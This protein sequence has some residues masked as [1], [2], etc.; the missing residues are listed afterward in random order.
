MALLWQLHPAGALLRDQ[1]PDRRTRAA[2]AGPRRRARARGDAREPRPGH[3]RVRSWPAAPGALPA[4]R[5]P[6]PP[7][8]LRLA[9]R[10][11]LPVRQVGDHARPA[12]AQRGGRGPLRGHPVRMPAP[13]RHQGCHGAR[14]GGRRAR[15]P[16]AHGGGGD[17]RAS[18]ARPA[19]DEARRAPRERRDRGRHAAAA[20]SRKSRR[21]SSRNGCRGEGDRVARRRGRPRRARGGR[22]AAGAARG[23][24]C[25]A[26]RLRRRR[27][28]PPRGR[29]WP[30]PGP[31]VAP[32]VRAGRPR[33]ASRRPRRRP[34]RA[35][36][37][38]CGRRHGA[39]HAPGRR[40]RA[41]AA[42]RGGR[43]GCQGR[44]RA[45]GNDARR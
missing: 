44:A 21:R 28:A 30:A 31:S 24:G 11:R 37:R 6:E 19:C 45:M 13:Y 3:G 12:H 10:P 9:A 25:A 20:Y 35:V 42:A 27:P 29:R 16:V 14:R 36:G 33:R 15:A 17:A 26:A 2:C 38:R 8:A 23:A 4:A 32:G 39:S 1:A 41:P 7:R 34:A 5:M 22:G 40:L 18:H 43:G